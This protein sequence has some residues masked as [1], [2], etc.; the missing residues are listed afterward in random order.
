MYGTSSRNCFLRD[1]R[2]STRSGSLYWHTRPSAN[3]DLLRVKCAAP[4][5]TRI[6]RDGYA[7]SLGVAN[8]RLREIPR[9]YLFGYQLGE[10]AAEIVFVQLA[11]L[12]FLG[13]EQAPIFLTSESDRSIPLRQ[14]IA[15]RQ[16]RNRLFGRVLAFPRSGANSHFL[17]RANHSH[18]RVSNQQ[19]RLGHIRAHAHQRPVIHIDNRRASRIVLEI[20]ARLALR[21]Q[22]EVHTLTIPVVPERSDVRI[23]I[24]SDRR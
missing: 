12:A 23:T 7:L 17:A 19:D 18:F 9:L 13:G 21:S 20:L 14:A 24:L 15:L 11:F 4:K 22:R 2:R 16:H 8:R 10:Y 3:T 1:S 5:F 6:E